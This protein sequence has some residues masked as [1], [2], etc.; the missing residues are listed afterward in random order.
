MSDEDTFKEIKNPETQKAKG[1]SQQTQSG[2]IVDIAEILSKLGSKKSNKA[3]NATLSA[4]GG[5]IYLPN[6]PILGADNRIGSFGNSS[7]SF[8]AGLTTEVEWNE[9]Y[10]TDTSGLSA[11]QFAVDYDE[12]VIA[13]NIDSGTTAVVNYKIS[14]LIIEQP[15]EATQT[16]EDGTVTYYGYAAPGSD[17]SKPV[18]KIKKVDETGDLF[19]VW[20]DGNANYDNIWDN[21]A[22]LSYS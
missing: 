9:T 7:V 11:G 5:W 16:D 2:E 17:T 1:G 4:G 3:L 20:A 8:S 15:D 21:R 18:W 19:I 6:A 14:M 12:G 22:S 13:Y 10:R